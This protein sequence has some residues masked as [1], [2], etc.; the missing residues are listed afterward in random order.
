MRHETGELGSLCAWCIT[1]KTL[2]THEAF[3]LA[4]AAEVWVLQL[5]Y[6]LPNSMDGSLRNVR[7]IFQRFRPLALEAVAC[8][9]FC[10][11]SRLVR[12]IEGAGSI[13]TVWRP[14]VGSL[15]NWKGLGRKRSLPEQLISR[16]F[17]SWTEGNREGS[18]LR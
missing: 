16:R 17:S 18:L 15:L 2:N 11:S 14:M 6:L 1:E 12:H 13:Q 8:F 7:I 9:L 5:L 3:A 10:L 4:T